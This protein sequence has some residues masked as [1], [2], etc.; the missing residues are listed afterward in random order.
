VRPEG[1]G[2]TFFVESAGGVLA[3][4]TRERSGLAYAAGFAGVG[5]LFRYSFAPLALP[6]A[7]RGWGL[8]AGL[9]F[10]WGMLALSFAAA[11]S[12]DRSPWKSGRLPAL[13]GFLV[14]WYGVAAWLSLLDE[15]W[16]RYLKAF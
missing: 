6:Q 14:G 12:L 8:A 2:G 5:Y 13:F 9:T 10:V 16:L 1:R 4:A 11:V 15:R 3:R 7:G